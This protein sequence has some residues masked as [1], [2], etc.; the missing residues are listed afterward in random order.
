MV[1]NLAGTSALLLGMGVL[2]LG[3]GLQGTLLG[4]SA[5]RAGFAPFVT[6]LIMACYYMGYMGGSV[7]APIFVQRVGHIR[8]FSALTAVASVVILLHG[9]FVTPFAWAVLRAISGACFA[10]IYVVAESW[11]ND[12]ASNS[13]RGRLL[14]TYMV[15]TYG[16]LALGQFLLNIGEPLDLTLFILVAMLISLAVVPVALTAQRVP[17]FTVP[18]HVKLRDL[19]A[20]SPLG[21]VAMAV[22]GMLSGTFFGMGPVY[23]GLL[24]LDTHAVARFMGLGIF[25]AVLV[26]PPLGRLSDHVDR[27]S[28][29]IIVCSLAAIAAAAALFVE[30]QSITALII[31]TACYGGLSL[32]V[33]SLAL[34]HV[35]DHLRPSEMV[36]AS[37]SLLLVNGAGAVLGPIVVSALMQPL[38]PS[39]YFASLLSLHVLL[40]GYALL[41]KG[42]RAPVPSQDKHRFVI[43]VQP[44]ATPTGS[45]VARLARQEAGG[46]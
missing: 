46:Q 8:V 16:S 19:Y 36:A 26:H 44:Q 11:I 37:S 28:I 35:N 41:R 20:I 6:G 17:E 18:G 13:N 1:T 34:A 45:A 7:V 30:R 38:G 3:A 31:A 42:L 32:T 15:I 14:A 27:R 33:Y 22:A 10:G 25:A 9:M 12:R 21:V 4:L 43:G 5:A 40:A 29:L 24:G 2:M 39:A 23:A